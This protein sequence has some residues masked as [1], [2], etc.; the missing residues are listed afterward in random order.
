MTRQV[1]S[2]ASGCRP[3]RGFWRRSRATQ[4]VAS[5]ALLTSL[6]AVGCGRSAPG[7]AAAADP[8]P[9][10][11]TDDVGSAT[12]DTSAAFDIAGVQVTSANTVVL[13]GSTTVV[14]Q[15]TQTTTVAAATTYEVQ[16]GD[17]LSVIAERFGVS[18]E[19]ISRANNITDVDE[20]KPG[21]ELVIPAPSS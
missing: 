6:V 20:I 19:A 18:I 16:P 12:E 2:G 9:D 4:L 14:T 21:Q 5:V 7:D 11:E 3:Q 10:I 15:T 8:N 13:P 17:T 1:N